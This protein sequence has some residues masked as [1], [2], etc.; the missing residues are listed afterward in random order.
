V[1]S[2]GNWLNLVETLHECWAKGRILLEVD[3]VLIPLK[4]KI[5][6]NHDKKIYKS[7]I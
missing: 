3:L 1:D 7:D 5:P 2:A 6:K 4:K